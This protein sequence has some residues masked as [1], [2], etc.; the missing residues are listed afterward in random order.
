[1]GWTP[2]SIDDI[3]HALIMTVVMAGVKAIQARRV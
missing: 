3:H 1:M 2:R